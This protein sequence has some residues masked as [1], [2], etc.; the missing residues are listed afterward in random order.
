ERDRQK[1]HDHHPGDR[2]CRAGQI[3][4]ERENGDRV[5]PIAELRDRLT[6]VKQTKV[7]VPAEDRQV[8]IQRTII[9][10]AAQCSRRSGSTRSSIASALAEW[11][12]CSARAIHASDA[13]R[14]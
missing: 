4:Q 11:A 10:V 2:R 1:L 5:E 6:D 14:S 12:S 3:E 7:T 8:G 13:P 9:I